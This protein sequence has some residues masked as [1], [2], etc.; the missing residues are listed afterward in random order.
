M[1]E[2]LARLG[3]LPRGVLVVAAIV[4]CVQLVLQAYALYDLYRR[5]SVM[6]GRK[7]IWVVIIII[8]NL[9]GAIIYLGMGR[10]VY[11]PGPGEGERAGSEKA[12]RSAIDHLYG[13]RK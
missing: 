10:V 1:E 13:D 9:L 12:T 6:G 8:G 7:W 5:D 3:T 2:I 11:E 4:A